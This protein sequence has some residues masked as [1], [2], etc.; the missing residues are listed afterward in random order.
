MSGSAVLQE[1]PAKNVVKEDKMRFNDLMPQGTLKYSGALK[2]FV[3]LCFGALA[4]GAQA[5]PINDNFASAVTLN[6]SSGT[7]AGANGGATMEA[8]EPTTVNDP[9]YGIETINHSIWFKWTAT[10]SGTVTFSTVGST[11][12]TV[13]TVYTTTNGLCSPSLTLVAENDDTPNSADLVPPA[14]PSLVTF[15]AIAGTTYYISVNGNAGSVGDDTGRVTL[16]WSLTPFAVPNIDSGSFIFTR[17]VYVVSEMDAGQPLDGSVTGWDPGVLGA[18]LTVTRMGGAK[19]RVLVDF[20]TFSQT[21][22]NQMLTNYFGTNITVTMITPTGVRFTTNFSATVTIF[23]NFYQS[24]YGGQ[25]NYFPY[26]GAS[27]NNVLQIFNN[28]TTNNFTTVVFPPVTGPLSP[29]P[30][31]FP[32]PGNLTVGSTNFPYGYPYIVTSNLFS[33]ARSNVLNGVLPPNGTVVTN[34]GLA[35]TNFETFWTNQFITNF[36]GANVAISYNVAGGVKLFT[37]YFFTNIVFANYFITNAIYTNG[38]LSGSVMSTTRV[39]GGTTNLYGYSSNNVANPVTISGGAGGLSP[40]PTNIPP[41]GSINLGTLVTNDAS[42]NT[43]IFST[44]AFSLPAKLTPQIVAADGDFTPTNGTLVFDDYQMSQDFIVGVQQMTDAGGN[45]ISADSTNL[46]NISGLI[47][48]AIS[49]PRLDQL[50]SS[51]LQQPTLGKGSN[52]L[53]NALGTLYDPNLILPTPSLF[54]FERGSFRVD[55]DVSGHQAVVYVTRSPGSAVA[56][57]VD[58]RIDFG[59]NANQNNQFDVQAG[60]DYARPHVLSFP[61][62]F[63]VTGTL[64]WAAGDFQPKAIA[65]P[66][67]NNGLVDFNRDM[68]VEIF[69]PQPF[70]TGSGDVGND[71]GLVNTATV[72]IL[73]DASTHGQQPAGAVDRDWNKDHDPSS[74]PPQLSFPGTQG[75]VSGN[76]NVNSGT[77][78][79]AVT[80]PDGKTIIAGAFISFDSNPYNRIVRLMTNGFQ[81][82]TFLVRPNSGANDFISCMALQP[83]GKILIGG[84]FTSFNGAN[85]Y[86]IARL[87]PDGTLD[88]SFNP[89]VGV[90]GTNAMVWSLALEPNGQIIIGGQFSSVNGTNCNSVARLNF[91]GSLDTS[92]NPGVGPDGVVNAVAVDAVGRVFIGGEFDNVSGVLRGGVARLNVDGT[93]DTAFDPGVGTFNPNTGNTDPVNALLVQPDGRLLVGGA[94]S[95][96]QMAS[97][98]GIVRLNPDGTLD[99]SFNPGTGT[100]NFDYSVSDSVNCITLQPDG[101]ILI[102]GD[103]IEYN[104]TRRVGIA[105]LY[106]YGSLDTTFMD[107]AYN[108]FAG[109]IN[110]YHNPNAVNN[111]LYPPINLRNFVNAISVE[112]GT[113]NVIVG[114]SFLQVGGGTTRDSILPRSNVARL[115]GG[116][117]AG[118]G[119]I[120]F[121]YNSY[122]V[123]KSAG[124]L[125]VSLVRSNGNLSLPLRTNSLG[126]A[127]V[128]FS[129]NMAEPGP[130]IATGND[131]AVAQSQPTWP[132]IW[133]SAPNQSWEQAPAF[134]GPNF[135]CLPSPQPGAGVTLNI[136][137]NNVFSGNLNA[138]MTLSIPPIPGAPFTLGGENIPVG[139]ALGWQDGAPMTIIDNNFHPGVIGFASPTFKVNENAGTATITV[140]RTNGT[141]N[142]VQITY[143]TMDGSALA[144]V[145]YTNVSGTL[146]FQPTDTSKTFTIPIIFGTV[147]Q[148]DKTLNLLLTT[149]TGGAT[150]GQSN[151]VL[152]IVNNNSKNGHIGFTSSSYSATEDSGFAYVTVSRLG[153]SLGTLTVTAITGDLTATNG[154][155]YIGSTNVLT[156]NNGDVTNKVIAI[157]LIH[158]GIFTSNLTVSLILTNGLLN[159]SSSAGVL[160]F[161]GTNAVLNILNVDFPGTVEFSTGVY[162]V[163]KF[164]GSAL[165]PVQ[166]TAGSSGTLAVNYRTADG[167]ALNG[168]N[169]TAVSGA[170]VFTNGEV[171]KYFSVPINGAASNGLVSLNLILTN[172]MV[173]GNSTPWNALGAPSNA[174]LNIIDSSRVNETPGSADNTYSSMAGFNDAVFA[175]ALQP[176]NSQLIVG[177]NFTMAN[178]VPRQRLARL[179][180]DGTLDATFLFPSL[181]FGADGSVRALAI[182]SDGRIL[183]GGFFTNMNSVVSPSI[184]RLNYD[185]SLDSQFNPGSGAD[186]PVYAL[187]ETFVGGQRKVLVAGAFTRLNGATYNG[188]GRLN[189]DGTQDASFNSGGLGANA[190]VYALAVQSN[191]KILI[192]GDFTTV[193]GVLANHIARL[194]PDGSVDLSFTNTT[195]SAS[196]RAIALQP[197]GRILVGGLFTTLNGNTNFNRIARLNSADG[198]SD[199]TFIPG[200][201]AN[202]LVSSIALQTDARIVLG[203][204]FT[205]FSGVTRNRVTRLNPDGTVDPTINF[206]SG[207]NDSLNA[208]VVQEDTIQGYPTNVPDEKIIIGGAFQQYNGQPQAR[209]ARIFGGS[210]AGSGAFEFSSATYKVDENGVNAFVTV[211]RTGGTSGTN[212][213]GSGNIIVPFATTNGG[214]AQAGINYTPVSSNLVFPMGEVQQVVQIP[215]MDDGVVTPDLTVNL[216][217]TPQTPAGVGNQ[218]AA[219]LTIVNVDSV[220]AFS[221]STYQ[222]PKNVVNGVAAVNVVRQGSTTGTASVVFNTTSGGTATPG[223]DYSP[224]TNA[225]LTFGPGITNVAVTVPIVNNLLP[226]GNR[227]VTMKL[228]GV[229]NSALSAPTNATLTIIDTV[230]SP[231][232]LSFLNTNLTVSEGNAS[233]AITVVRTNGANGIVSASYVTVAGTAVPG[234]NYINTTNTITLGDGV[235]SGTILIPLVDNNIVQGPVNFSVVLSNPAGGA[236]LAPPT[237]VT[238][239]VLDNDTGLAFASATNTIPENSGS[240]IISVQR[241]GD[242]SGASSANYA[243]ADGTAH[244][245]VNYTAVSGTLAFA[246][247]EALK[248]IIIPII[249]DPQVTGDLKFSLNLSSLSSGTQLVGPP[250]TTIV[251]Q[252]AD[253]G[254]SF[255]TTNTIVAK[256]AGQAVITVI[257]SN[258]RVEPVVT[259]TN[260]VPLQVNYSTADGSALAGVDYQAVNGTLVFTNGNGTNTFVVPIINNGFV[261][262]NKTFTVSLSKPTAPGQLVPPSTQTVTITESNPGF[263]F[264]QSA[265][266]VFK[267]GVAATITVNRIGNTNS[268][269]SVSY[270]ATNGTAIDGIN[271]VATSGT[272]VFSNGVT[273]QTFNVPVINN[274]VVQPNHTVLLQLLNPANGV[275]V[276]PSAATLTILENGGSFVIP[277]GAQ[278]VTNYTSHAN[279]G[280]IHSNDTVQVLFAFRDAAGLGVANLN[281]TLLATNGVL[282]PNPVSN[283]YGPLTALGHSVSRAYTFTAQGT[284]GG[285]INPTF[286]LYDNATPLGTNQFTFSLGTVTTTFSNSAA[287][288]ISDNSAAL[289]YPAV[290]NVSGVGGSVVKATVTLNKLAHT[291]PADVEALVASPAGINTLLMANTGGGFSVTN[292][293]LTFDSTVTNTLPQNGRMTTSTNQPTSYPVVLPFH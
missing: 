292:I 110:H 230:T 82:P 189:D 84:K 11:F 167:S 31:N 77:V 111:S 250:A 175:L 288:I 171:F 145:D 293:V 114:G 54:N 287:I 124:T 214:S 43:F 39:M 142:V 291:Y 65:I 51:D 195:A 140:T 135:S 161:G 281:A 34:G 194:N 20:A 17:G 242:T 178:G 56:A 130:G 165:I 127:M 96:I 60:S 4:F 174:A 268:T 269:A 41:P 47:G 239:T 146:T 104:Q 225:L 221:T 3:M 112:P 223:T 158:D 244:A 64:S 237:S 228:S 180:S 144:G 44:N 55:T 61:D 78:Y 93:L 207:A 50:E 117:T 80:Q 28:Y 23:T 91:D 22:T 81:D 101:N 215:V 267:N 86:H 115:I 75:G 68:L 283:N 136:T 270:L 162:S 32:P 40:I 90:N 201:G 53:V 134:W 259:S 132:T 176:K 154:V 85:R 9:A 240:V 58:Y 252:D 170:L 74:I 151:A 138:N 271:F 247:G 241:I 105:R 219:V 5:Q 99:T 155:N 73:F 125:Y 198:S 160:G 16:K 253:A 71:L 222:V 108:Q 120:A 277:A 184:A 45:P 157:P 37:N 152:T 216:A 147:T 243:T 261:T 118:P 27:T 249:D 163:K 46:N 88:V 150:L 6:G 285:L 67:A 282:S 190:T 248:T 193:N 131:F 123:D 95:F 2:F 196:V 218:I 254:L 139:V 79:A 102:G 7:V 156:W 133:A 49:N 251:V 62:F 265:Y 164:G 26:P 83:D 278:V 92:F 186:N 10:N 19:G 66:I 188:I 182:Q 200:L 42:G 209:L 38:S 263:K 279:D 24:Y 255:S 217:L 232:T 264:S 13:L 126:S 227:T 103:F 179:N 169:Y 25:Y 97:Y 1:W 220:I 18:R 159:G 14:Y 273:T 106:S 107:T 15:T 226:E 274:N 76:A 272:L 203:G 137:N 141:G 211:I 98:S 52:S 236:T 213:D 129:T 109:L 284:N 210:E 202:D 234:I 36:Y 187:A 168:I 172:A 63:S 8:C 256:S 177:G 231:G 290:I 72:T 121:S 280:I 119:N 262:G 260:V 233:A 113:T 94:F 70:P 224:V 258:P 197:D 59:P 173:V 266:S 289:P 57:T 29:V 33:F 21:Y 245:G 143:S 149:P 128:L 153:A 229:V 166:R 30:T 246:P 205:R 191:G 212:L 206:G 69:N 257:C 276:A 204:Q 199:N 12:D 116:S 35:Y 286:A 208:V 275:L 148:P 235:T 238:V 181:A 183:V 89:G 100:F 192:G 87:Q 122:S 48:V 185:G